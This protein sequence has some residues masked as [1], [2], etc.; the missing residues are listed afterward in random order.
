MIKKIFAVEA[1]E[2]K[3]KGIRALG[4]LLAT[5]IMMAV[6]VQ[7]MALTRVGNGV[8]SVTSIET[9]AAGVLLSPVW[10]G[11]A[12][13]VQVLA[14]PF[15]VGMKVSPLMR[16]VSMGAGW[17]VAA[18]FLVS[19]VVLNLTGSNPV[20][21]F[22]E[23]MGVPLGGLFVVLSVMIGVAMGWVTWG[24]WPAKELDLKEVKKE[25]ERLAKEDKYAGVLAA[26]RKEAGVKEEAVKE[27][28]G[29]V[30]AQK[31]KSRAKKTGARAK[32]TT[33]K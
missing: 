15:I 29:V 24:R 23:V 18:N 11:V 16:L 7:V 6:V 20:V 4:C 9:G 21:V 19:V 32:K 22:A 5:M 2:P 30:V 25:Q 26:A 33:T 12:V 3:L 31:K 28:G 17:A 8:V 14:L 27:D 10:L 13:L 1:V